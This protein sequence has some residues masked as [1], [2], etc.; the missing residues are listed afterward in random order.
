MIVH[1]YRHESRDG[2][3]SSGTRVRSLRLKLYPFFLLYY[4]GRR[5]FQ[6]RLGV[7]Q[8]EDII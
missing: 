6:V 3:D 7:N 2:H 5:S 4:R 1:F 8:S